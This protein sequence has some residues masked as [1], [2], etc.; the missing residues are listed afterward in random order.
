MKKR[1]ASLLGAR[2]VAPCA[3]AAALALC[4]L[5]PASSAHAQLR[6]LDLAFR[7]PTDARVVGFHVYVASMS[8]GYGD[9]RD[10]INFI[11]PV[12]GSGLAHFALTGL[13][14]FA[15]VYIALKS[16]DAQGTES[17]FSNEIVLAAQ[18]QCLVTGCNDNNP[19]T[20]DTCTA[21]GC[22][23]D[24]APRRG[25]TCD[26]GNAMTFND[27]CQASGACSGTL[28][29][30]NLDA[31]CSAPA[32]ACAG[33]RVCV[34]HMCQPGSSPLPDET[35]CNDGNASTRYD[36]CRSGACRGFA[37]GNDSQC[38]DG[39]A[40]N[41][42]ERCV[43]NSCVAGTPMVCNDGNQC[44]GTETCVGSS[45]VPGTAMQCPAT[46]GPCFDAF[47][48]PAMGCRVQVHP[49]GEMCT[50]AM[51]GASGQC[52]SGVCVAMAPPPTDPNTTPRDPRPPVT[53]PQTT[54][55]TAFGAPTD[56]HQELTA[57][58]ETQRKIVWTAPLHPMGSVLQY[59]L[60]SEVSWRSLRAMPEEQMGCTGQFAVTLQGLSSTARYKFRVSG[61]AASGRVWSD[62]FALTPGPVNPR[63][64]YK[65]A[66]FADN[67][68]AAAAQSM[69]AKP[70][71]QQ[72]QK[73]RFPLVLG[74]GG[75]ALSSEAIAAGAATNAA[76]AVALW[77]QQAS[78]VTGGSIFA[79]VLGDTEVESAT[80]A[81][82]A[83]DYAEYMQLAGTTETPH[84][85]YSYDFGAT[86]FVAVHA[87]T[88]ATIHP[89]TSAGLAH[90]AWIDADLAAARAKGA[91]WI[92]VY[93]HSD[94]FS[95][96]KTDASV[97]AVRTALGTILN[98]Y[99][100]NLVLSGEGNSYERTKGMRGNTLTASPMPVPNQVTTATDGVVFVRAGSGGRTVF[101]PW[102]R[103]A[104]PTWSA[105]RD[106]THAIYVQVSVADNVLLVTAYGLD[107]NGKR[108]VVDTLK[109]F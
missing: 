45:C 85:T 98:R 97:Q 5:L 43:S 33:P 21:T 103:T 41:G 3:L 105:F 73:G 101:T 4:A 58:P 100:V 30:C 39:Q 37:C 69:E 80:N 107:D 54:C 26:D 20:V 62:G 81:E 55:T 48:D 89:S 92:V 76:Q 31:D 96:D 11:P 77:K 15:N 42:S 17:S 22:V 59:R 7:P 106:N 66:F 95:S 65:F 87:P 90:L 9:F 1:V 56:V 51:S 63:A 49:D 50:T 18:Q 40:C 67:G 23:F 83:A 6:D 35:T 16:Y 72:I 13:E 47:C 102:L 94:L 29:Q 93:M 78:L 28:A 104:Q 88:L 2:W 19:C 25:T 38:S 44:N 68:L 12:D 86:H 46:D 10:D 99:G 24:P 82:R 70:V 14:Q 64:K 32:D 53:T 34:A 61:A 36:V 109:I 74:G 8:R 79:P 84:Q 57:D 52:A 60:E 71:L 91:R 108:I 27:M 75:Y